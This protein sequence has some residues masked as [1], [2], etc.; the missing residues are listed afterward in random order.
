MTSDRQEEET[1]LQSRL[2]SNCLNDGASEL[3]LATLF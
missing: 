1:D 3:K 2:S